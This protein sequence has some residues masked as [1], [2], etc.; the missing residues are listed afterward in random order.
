MVALRSPDAGRFSRLFLLALACIGLRALPAAA[1][2]PELT[3]RA[4][5]SAFGHFLLPEATSP[6]SVSAAPPA[7]FPTRI[8]LANPKIRLLD[9][10]DGRV[11]VEI[12]SNDGEKIAV[13]TLQEFGSHKHLADRGV[14]LKDRL[15]DPVIETALG[16][17]LVN[18]KIPVSVPPLL[19]RITG[20]GESNIR[21]T[22]RRRI[23]LSGTSRYTEGQAQ[24]SGQNTSK[25]PL[26]N[27]EQ[28]SQLNVQ[29]TIGDRISIELQQDS[30]SQLDL[31]ES[32]R[33]RYSG[34]EDDIV[35]EIE[36]GSTSLALPGTRLV[37][38]NAP[39]RGG[40]FGIKARGKLGGLDLTVVTTQDKAA[41]GK[42]TY[43]GRTEE[44]AN[45]TRDY[46]FIEDQYFF[47]DEVYR[48]AYPVE[49]NVGD[50]INTQIVRVFA[51]DFIADNDL[52]DKAEPAI[53]Y[54]IWDPNSPNVAASESIQKGGKEEGNFHELA[55]DEFLVDPRGYLLMRSRISRGHALAV[56][57]QTVAGNVYGDLGPASGTRE[58]K[59]IKARNQNP[60]LAPGDDSYPT[61]KLSWRN[62]YSL[63]GRNIEQGGLE[64]SI[65]R[66]VSGQEDLDNQDGTH[67]IQIFGLD[68]HRNGATEST[69]PDG[70][71]DIDSES[72][73]PGVNLLAGHLIFPS[74]EPFGSRGLGAEA[75]ND[76]SRVPEIY[77]T[78]NSK[79]RSDASRFFLRIRSRGQATQYSLG[80]GVVENSEQV[81]L[82]N[83]RLEKGKDYSIDYNFGTVRLLGD[84]SELAADPTANL[85]INYSE[86]DELGLGSTQKSL[87]GLRAEYPLRNKSLLGLTILYSSQSAP[88]QRVQ[89]GQEPTRTFIW[90]ANAQLRFRPT[91]LTEL[92]NKLPSVATTVPSTIDI[93]FEVAQS[94]PNPNTKGIAYIDD[95]EGAESLLAFPISKL[96]W[97]QSSRPDPTESSPGSYRRGFLTW[98]N[99]VERDRVR[100]LQIQPGRTD[101]TADQDIVDIMVLRFQPRQSSPGVA[102]RSWG[103]LQRFE[104]TGLDLSRSKFLEIWVR[105][106]SGRLHIDLGDVSERVE[107]HLDE[108]IVD[109]A[110]M[111]I[112]DLA[113]L[114]FE[115]RALESLI[116]PDPTS[117]RS[118]DTPLGGL[119]SGDN[120][121][122]SEEDVGMDGLT[123]EQEAEI[124][125]ILFPNG[126]VPSDPSND[127]FDDVNFEETIITLRYPSGVNGTQGNN[128]E[129][130]SFPDTEDLN[131]NGILDTDENF[132]RYSVEFF[133]DRVR[134][135]N[136]EAGVYDDSLSVVVEGSQSDLQ[137]GASNP[138]WR[139]IRIPLRGKDAPRSIV[140]R[141]DTAFAN[142]IEFV[143]LWVEHNAPTQIEVYTLDAIGSE[144]Q[145]DPSPYEFKVASVGT[146]NP[147]Y[148]PPPGLE[149]DRDPTTGVILL[150]RSLTMEVEDLPPGESVSASR[151]FLQADNYTRYGRMQMLV[152]GGASFPAPAD[153][154]FG[155]RDPIELALRFTSVPGDTSNFYEYS[156]HIFQDWT[157]ELNTFDLDLDLMT[158]L[159]G[160]LLD[161]KTTQRA[162]SDTTVT[163][164]IGD[165][166]V[167]YSQERNQ[168]E[169]VVNGKT[170]SVRGNPSLSSIKAFSLILRNLSDTRILSGELWANELSVT[171]IR[172]K[173]AVSALLDFRTV[174][175]DL[176]SFSMKFERRSGD[177]QSLA[178]QATG[179]TNTLFSF[180][181]ELKLGRFLPQAWSTSLPLRFGI[182][183]S[184]SVPRIRSG[185]DIVLTEDQKGNESNVRNQSRVNISFRKT[186]AKEDPALVSRLIF[187]RVTG[188]MNF[189][190][191]QT[192]TGAITRR[193]LNSNET[194]T[195]NFTYDLKWSKRG[196]LK[197]LTWVP[198]ITS[199]K[200][201]EFFYLPSTVRYN[202]KMN[203][204]IRDSD[205]FSAVGGDTTNVTESRNETFVLDETFTIKFTPFRS[206]NADY[207]LSVNRDLRDG[208]ALSAFQFGRETGRSQQTSFRFS[209]R[210]FKWLTFNA[211]YQS[212]YRERLETGGER[213]TYG[214][215]RRGLRATRQNPVSG[216]FTLNIP[217]L[218]APLT[219]RSPDGGFSILRTF[220]RFVSTL[221]SVQV[222]LQRNTTITLFGLQER[223]GLAYQLSFTDST[224][225]KTFPSGLVTR[226]DTRLI[227][228]KVDVT[229]SV[230]LPTGIQVQTGYDFIHNSNF[231]TNSTEDDRV[232]FPSIDAGW[233]GLERLPVLRALFRSARIDAGYKVSSI[234]RGD[235]GLGPLSI[236][237]DSKLTEYS[238][239]FNWNANWRNRMS[240]AF[241]RNTSENVE[242]KYERN[243]SGVDVPLVDREI[244]TTITNSSSN[245]ATLKYTLSSRLFRKLQS[246]LDMD[247]SFQQSATLQEEFP[248]ATGADTTSVIR[249][250]EATWSAQLQAQYRFSSRF[251]GGSRLRHE[252]R[253]DRLRDRTDKTWEFRVWGE[254]SF[255]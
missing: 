100:L 181:S 45:D 62:V 128:P 137:G 108:E 58:L 81:V 93:D 69:P 202:V 57:Y 3:P 53:G 14:L 246:N 23:D 141:P 158:Q 183:R 169:M 165:R 26:I 146:D 98:Y 210:I 12:S 206:L 51:N 59:L 56:A 65:L 139:L 252:N 8:N 43:Q 234:R 83:K 145:E 67:Y 197:P 159:K 172:K 154:L 205:S 135:F 244:G 74:L 80:F 208:F 50:L 192:E 60:P 33:L 104:E 79:A 21:I 200:E 236:T 162:T 115:S 34:V 237:Q 224:T 218:T 170:Y 42:K 215:S 151:A 253:K 190:T 46:Q 248:R 226:V 54:A 36:A 86:K 94:M 106:R 147:V 177:F 124:Y 9:D 167:H 119:S 179:T 2:P 175:A 182:N 247:M 72:E 48:N 116:N 198:F 117:F 19:N 242:L 1:A 241:T 107:L 121:T 153:T 61:W 216:R 112:F 193:S 29:G 155:S 129:R 238:P 130:N 82:N 149:L 63:G 103:G 35:Q 136:P 13:M 71:I 76:A 4:P 30:R 64:V 203:R 31:G 240:T 101:V 40:L 164:K 217:V 28:E 178:G 223:P 188:S 20:Q 97:S 6:L 16:G 123:D 196:S 109:A 143:R 49:P 118:E 99:P 134:G 70:L 84:A 220:G 222:S 125:R 73:I 133:P 78:T 161:F 90:D 254:I 41:S 201:A 144:W 68:T 225:A 255:N 131:K 249:K 126:Q 195:G 75:L 122:T 105:G 89:V 229:G 15:G 96:A 142:P 95:F 47:F 38:F 11:L 66:E 212:N 156:G 243:V 231:G 87:L 140:G 85:I 191:N 211:A 138:P 22:G 148:D 219:K 163:V 186:P 132:T 187:D 189:L 194:L 251:T 17:G 44:T 245:K 166:P 111:G 209:P 184:N 230:R 250:D 10:S 27:F 77:N 32:L 233:K 52:E 180:D 5:E 199:L 232:V 18:I 7:I 235:G 160:H 176:A 221:Q 228:D 39:N 120:I 204:N 110:S 37:G 168:I 91:L 171:D 239:L 24:S 127:N 114:S 207:D 214:T 55:E 213:S 152:H 185:S 150:E 113:D 92:A 173:K 174:I 102:E 157:P 25:V 227:N 88:S